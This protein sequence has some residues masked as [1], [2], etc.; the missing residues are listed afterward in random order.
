MFTNN[1][2]TGLEKAYHSSE[3]FRVNNRLS[4]F[5]NK[6]TKT[7]VKRLA[8]RLYEDNRWLSGPP[9]T[10]SV[11]RNCFT[12]IA[13]SNRYGGNSNRKMSASLHINDN[14]SVRVLFYHEYVLE[15]NSKFRDDMELIKN[16]F[17]GE[18]NHNKKDSTF[19]FSSIEDGI[20]FMK[21]ATDEYKVMGG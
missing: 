21:K 1:T 18:L 8:E 17:G 20:D 7:K 12:G 14:G 5:A 11:H 19:T 16:K 2:L 3:M 15:N 4:N 9:T 13:M 6:T 10:S